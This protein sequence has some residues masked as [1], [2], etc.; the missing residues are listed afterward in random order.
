MVI[1][2]YKIGDFSKMS[3]TTI[4]TLRY[5]EN[6][7]LLLPAYVDP[8]TSYRYYESRQLT[9]LTKIVSLRQAGLSI[10]DIKAMLRG[11]N[12]R[13]ILEKRKTELE[14]EL[15]TLNNQLSKINYLMEDVNIK[16]EITIKKYLVILYIIEMVLFLI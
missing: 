13:E 12:T 15:N 5:Y 9:D 6:E 3:K 11:N 1:L 4:K 8:Y 10:N 14:C 16:N 2:M 7:G